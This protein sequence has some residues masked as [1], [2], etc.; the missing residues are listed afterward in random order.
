MV[1]NKNINLEKR[2]Y[3]VTALTFVSITGVVTVRERHQHRGSLHRHVFPDSKVHG[4][5][6]GPIWVL[7]APDGS[8]VDPMI[9]AMRV[10]QPL[11]YHIMLAWW[12]LECQWGMEPGW[13]RPFVIDWSKHRLE[14]PRSQWIVGSN[15]RQESQP[16]QRPLT[17]PLYSRNPAVRAA[18]GDCERVY[19]VMVL[20]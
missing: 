13:H 4:A 6:M 18:Q 7:P 5:N 15:D 8:H 17:V 12:H 3:F 14:L 11:D 10:L 20:V 16:F 2:Y 9:L 19:A 1:G